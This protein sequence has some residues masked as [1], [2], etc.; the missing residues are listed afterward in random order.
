MEDTYFENSLS[1][2]AKDKRAF[3]LGESEGNFLFEK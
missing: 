2:K 1:V 3:I